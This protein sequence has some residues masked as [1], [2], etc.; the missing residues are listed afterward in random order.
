[1]LGDR[2]SGQGH[3]QLGIQDSGEFLARPVVVP[4]LQSMRHINGTSLKRAL[5]P[6]LAVLPPKKLPQNFAFRKRAGAVRLDPVPFS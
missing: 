1:M 4:A 3:G 5:C 2:Q 6:E